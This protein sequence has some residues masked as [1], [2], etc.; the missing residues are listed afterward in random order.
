MGAASMCPAPCLKFL[1]Y[2]SL[3]FACAC[4]CVCVRVCVYMCRGQ[5]CELPLSLARPVLCVGTHPSVCLGGIDGR[6]LF[7]YPCTPSCCPL[8]LVFTL[9]S[10][11][12]DATH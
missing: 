7:Y 10:F 8:P 12:I 1:S 4:V 3:Y 2:I 11:L 9:L 5:S 6:L